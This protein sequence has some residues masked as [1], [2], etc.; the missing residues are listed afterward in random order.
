MK[1]KKRS[2]EINGEQDLNDACLLIALVFDR[3][4]LRNSILLIEV[5]YFTHYATIVMW[6]TLVELIIIFDSGYV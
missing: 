2:T 4:C 6:R 1:M 3:L 5:Y